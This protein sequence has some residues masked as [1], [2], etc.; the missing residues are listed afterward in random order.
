P[1]RILESYELGVLVDP[2]PEPAS[3][4]MPGLSW[5]STISP[6]RAR[7][8]ALAA[9]PPP[10]L[11]AISADQKTVF[12]LENDHFSVVGTAALPAPGLAL[13]VSADGSRLYVVA[14]AVAA[15]QPRQLVVIDTT[16]H[17]A[18]PPV[19]TFDIPN[20]ADG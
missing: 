7:G 5:V 17:L 18:N 6:G 15:A 1:N 10:F 12:Q 8:V 16:N 20:S 19:R 4:G 14:E 3:P 9:G 11:Y 13:A 2:K